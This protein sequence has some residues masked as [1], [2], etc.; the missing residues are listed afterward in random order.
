VEVEEPDGKITE[1]AAKVHFNN[2]VLFYSFFQYLICGSL[3]FN[4]YYT[5]INYTCL[6]PYFLIWLVLIQ[7]FVLPPC[8]NL[9]HIRF[10][11]SQTLSTL[12][13][14][15]EKNIYIYNTKYIPYE[16]YIMMNLMVLFWYS[17]CLYFFLHTLSNL[18]SFDFLKF[19]YALH[20]GKEGVLWTKLTWCE[21]V[22]V[23]YVFHYV[24]TKAIL[25][26]WLLLILKNGTFQNFFLFLQASLLEES[27]KPRANLPPL[28]VN[29]EDRRP[30]KLHYLGVSFGLTQELFRFWRKHN[31][32][33]FYVGQISVMI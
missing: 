26:V 24:I 10:F 30:E 17:R 28:L 13:K 15:I 9:L 23:L 7:Y 16:I 18:T 1:A 8:H 33:P 5:G 20:F 3:K 19:L 2:C 11:W 29:L 6:V 12:T 21:F 27:I 14:F 4:S 32:Y 25:Y 22:H 31:F